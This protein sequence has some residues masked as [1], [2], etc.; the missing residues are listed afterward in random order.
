MEKDILKVTDFTGKEKRHLDETIAL[1][2]KV[3]SKSRHSKVDDLACATLLQNLYTGVEN[4]LRIILDY[5]GIRP[6]KTDSWHK[7]IL[8]QSVKRQIISA[9]L[10]D[11][12]LAYLHFRHRHT[13]G[14]GYMLEREKMKPLIDNADAVLI[15][16]F[17]EMKAKGFLIIS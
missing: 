10:R 15:M 2:V 13:H 17:S 3:R 9:V 8:S 1:L 12:L 7:E 5:R 16:F 6:A 4:I 14:Y 11:E